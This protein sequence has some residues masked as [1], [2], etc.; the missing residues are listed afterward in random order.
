MGGSG[1]LVVKK[2]AVF[3]E[4]LELCGGAFLA[5]GRVTDIG[6]HVFAE[7]AAQGASRCFFR[8]C[9]PEEVANAADS[10]VTFEREG[11]HGRLLHEGCDFWE[12]WFVSYMGV[13]FDKDFIAE[14]HHF[15]AA[16]DELGFLEASQYFAG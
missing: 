5:V 16:D 7:V 6:H 12:E 15:D 10:V 14:G 2:L 9:R 4:A 1:G 3:E 8:I 11:D 13:M